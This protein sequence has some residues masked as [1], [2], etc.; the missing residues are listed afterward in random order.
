M[1]S[2]NQLT[3]ALT[4]ITNVRDTASLMTSEQEDLYDV[5][6][7]LTRELNCVG[8]KEFT[9]AEAIVWGQPFRRRA[10]APGAWVRLTEH[11]YNGGALFVFVGSNSAVPVTPHDITATD[12]ELMGAPSDEAK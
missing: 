3:D 10:W 7:M 8:D 9:L 5:H 4:K 1:L 11:V 12:Y 2:R 6:T